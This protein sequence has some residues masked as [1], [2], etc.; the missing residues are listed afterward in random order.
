MSRSTENEYVTDT[1]SEATPEET[2]AVAHKDAPRERGYYALSDRL[3]G[4]V[5]EKLYA[6]QE[7]QLA[8]NYSR[9][10]AYIASRNPI[11]RSL[12]AAIGYVKQLPVN[13][14]GMI[15]CVFGIYT[16]LIYLVKLYALPQYPAVFSHPVLGGVL[17]LLSIPLLFQSKPISQLIPTSRILSFF[18]YD[19]F[20]LPGLTGDSKASRS[21][22]TVAFLIGSLLGVCAFFVSP[23]VITGV[24][25]L[26]VYVT[27]CF[28]SPE[29]CFTTTMIA[30]PFMTVF[31]PN[32]TVI[33]C[34]LICLCAVSYVIKIALLKRVFRFELIDLFVLLLAFVYL[35]SGIVA[36][37]RGGS[38]APTVSF[39]CLSLGGYFLAAN[40]VKGDI[41]I[42]RTVRAIIFSS[43]IV[44]A[45]GLAEELLGF[46]V[47]S[48]IDTTR[49]PDIL[50][51]VTS[52]LGNPNVLG[53]FLVVTIP[54]ALC[55]FFISRHLSGKIFAGIVFAMSVTAAILTWSR[56][57]WL[58]LIVCFVIFAVAVNRRAIFGVVSLAIVAPLS[59]F[60]IPKTITDRFLSA[61]T[62]LDSSIVYR[63]SIW[64]SCASAATDNIAIGI[65]RGSFPEIYP[66]YAEQGAETAEHAHNVFLQIA[67]ESGIVALAVFILTI[68]VFVIAS[69]EY[70]RKDRT[71]SFRYLY[72]AG[73]SVTVSL[74]FFGMVDH[75]WYDNRM[76]LVFWIVLGIC[77]SL[78]GWYR[79]QRAIL[80]NER[81]SSPYAYSVDIPLKEE[82]SK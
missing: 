75:I 26:A 18:F 32:P 80:N 68:A 46:A 4:R 13:F 9:S 1:V 59:Y 12:A 50:G 47:N 53:E 39:L 54:F 34:S 79:A 11:T 33:L 6:K 30:I 7:R 31:F 35:I 74:L 41:S 63:F 16:V 17:V 56:G 29:F 70:R 48:W 25:L 66:E 81:S 14:Y 58:S 40:L 61:F 22:G 2:V 27:L 20:G 10:L 62:T 8:S 21:S 73:F 37:I 45:I 15:G 82:N 28:Y 76:L 43:A 71:R 67:L 19:L 55:S 57:T 52:T 23:Y 49:F 77:T 51:R 69:V 65:G 24:I 72:A 44:A 42:R 36:V 5:S 3:T 38:F 78:R 64:R 60:I